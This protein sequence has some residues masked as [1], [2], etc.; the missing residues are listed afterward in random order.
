M[1]AKRR[2]LQFV[3][4]IGGMLGS[5]YVVVAAALWLP[6]VLGWQI[7][8]VQS[9]LWQQLWLWGLPAA[10]VVLTLLFSIGQRL[11]AAQRNRRFER[12]A[13][14]TL[15]LPRSDA[16]S[17]G[18]QTGTQFWNQVSDLLPQGEQLITHLSRQLNGRLYFALTA[19][20]KTS[21]TLLHQLLADWPST[22]VRQLTALDATH[23]LQRA[24]AATVSIPLVTR[25]PSQPLVTTI[26][27]PLHAPLLELSRL[28]ETVQAGLWVQVRRDP[29]SKQRQLRRSR[30]RV[31]QQRQQIPSQHTTL[32]EKRADRASDERAGQPFLEVQL[33][34]WAA[35][36]TTAQAQQTAHSLAED[37]SAQFG[38][39]NPL[40]PQKPKQSILSLRYATYAGQPFTDRELGSIMHLLGKDGV[41]LAPLLATATARNLEPSQACRI[42][43]RMKGE[44]GRWK[45][46][47]MHQSVEM[48]STEV[49]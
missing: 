29:L 17:G 26:A 21:Q 2:L 48:L 15:I 46:E 37:I 6:P 5:V 22:Q 47:A 35:A 34:V 31:Q 49:R 33:K 3:M 30:Q 7:P 27:D 44:G 1:T 38:S 39:D 43:G 12:D 45:D 32:T 16:A 8:L 13:I 10:A 19:R 11:F 40:T 23:F 24:E 18:C 36:E 9:L 42:Y 20:P 41:R 14:T 4:I 25:Y 28:P